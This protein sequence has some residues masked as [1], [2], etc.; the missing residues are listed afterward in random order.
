MN[1]LITASCAANCGL[2]KD[3]TGK[4]FPAAALETAA[5]PQWQIILIMVLSMLVLFMPEKGTAKDRRDT[6]LTSVSVDWN[7]WFESCNRQ[8]LR[9]TLPQT[10]R[11]RL[12]AE[13]TVKGLGPLRAFVSGYLEGDFATL[14]RDIDEDLITMEA[15]E[16]YLSLALPRIN[17]IAGL[18]QIRWGDADS[19]SVV[20]VI[21]PVDYR[22]PVATGRSTKRLSVP[23]VDVKVDLD[24]GMLDLVAVPVPWVSRMAKHGSPW[25]PKDLKILRKAEKAGLVELRDGDTPASP[26]FGGRLKFYRQGFDLAFIYYHGYE[27]TPLY[28]SGFSR[29]SCKP[30]YYEEYKAYDTIGFSTAVSLEKSTLR[31]EFAFKYDYPFQ[32]R[33]ISIYRRND[34]QFLL[35]WDR[36]FLTNLFVNVQGFYFNYDG[37]R[38][39]PGIDRQRYGVTFNIEDKFFDE[40]LRSG[41]RGM[42]YMNN[43]DLCVEWFN[44]YDYDDHWKINFGIMTLWGDKKESIGQYKDN[45][46]VY[47]GFKYLF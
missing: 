11:Q 5:L 17:V 28:S 38:E 41:I 27:H 35:G 42:Y 9:H 19:M 20:D 47:A 23:A 6:P 14:N 4:A 2:Y 13:A 26:E 40:A 15:H 1:A 46:Y 43:Q 12:W 32:G 24:F 33:D 29:E 16:A 34:F 8:P 3:D 37:A 22:N 21:N 36:T 10:L 31:S 45:D 7:G 25:E 39:V 44:E 18:Q 30:V